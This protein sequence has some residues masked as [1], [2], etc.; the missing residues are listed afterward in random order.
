MKLNASHKHELWSIGMRGLATLITVLL[1]WGTTAPT[2]FHE[3]DIYKLSRFS[4]VSATVVVIGCFQSSYTG[5]LTPYLSVKAR[6][7]GFVVFWFT[8][9]IFFNLVWQLPYWSLPMIYTAPKTADGLFW[10]ILWWSYTLHDEWYENVTKLVIAFE[11]WW[12]GGNVVGAC[13]LYKFFYSDG[14][15]AYRSSLLYFVICGALQCYNATI[16]LFLSY[17]LSGFSHVPKH[18]LSMAVFWGV[19][20]FRACASATAAVFA[21]SLLLDVSSS[22]SSS[23]KKS[24]TF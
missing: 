22:R 7:L 21:S 15:Q 24:K 12:L 1:F 11:I 23:I 17:Y 2:L 3:Y 18:L 14:E 10:K 6:R 19:N 5:L 20:G 4:G 16:Y 9:S 13:G 8:G